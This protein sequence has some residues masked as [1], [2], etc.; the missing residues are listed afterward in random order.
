MFVTEDRKELFTAISDAQGEFTTVEKN[1]TNPH[2]R[3]KFAPLDSLV[4]MTRPILKKYGLSVMQLCD[5]PESGTG[6]IIETVIGHDSGQYICSKLFMPAMKADPQ[7]YGASITY[8]R[9]YALAAALGLVSDEDVDGNQGGGDSGKKDQKKDDKNPTP[10]PEGSKVATTDEEYHGRIKDGLNILF[11]DDRAAKLAKIE[12]LTTFTP[13]G[14]TEAVP[15]IKDYAKLTGQRL[16][17]LC[18]NIEKLL[19]PPCPKCHQRGF[20]AYPC[21]DNEPQQ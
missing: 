16:S 7:G 10:P 20:H 17:I 12:E 21:P 11:K 15:G 3:S 13:K 6:I 19:P 9:R 8:C 1:A 14:K 2:F 18:H 4:E 5:I